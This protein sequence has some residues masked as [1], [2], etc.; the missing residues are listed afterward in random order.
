MILKLSFPHLRFLNDIRVYLMP[1][2]NFY[3]PKEIKRVQNK[4]LKTCVILILWVIFTLKENIGIK[5]TNNAQK[6]NKKRTNNL[7]KP[8][9]KHKQNKKLTKKTKKNARKTNK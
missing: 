9:K 4:K 6:T 2:S 1:E 8:D 3:I 7:Q 5:V